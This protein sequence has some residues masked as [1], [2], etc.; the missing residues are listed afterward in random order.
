MQKLLS[1]LAGP[2]WGATAQQIYDILKPQLQ[3]SR[4]VVRQ[5]RLL[6]EEIRK[7]K[8]AAEKGKFLSVPDLTG[9]DEN[10]NLF[11]NEV[12]KANFQCQ[13]G[14]YYDF[15]P[16]VTGLRN[17][18]SIPHEFGVALDFLA[19]P[20]NK[21]TIQAFRLNMIIGRILNESAG[22]SNKSNAGVAGEDMVGALLNAAGLVENIDYRR[23]FKSL[24][25][26][27]TDFVI[28]NVKDHEDHNVE[29]FIAT[30][31]S[32]ND[33]ARLAASELK[34]G[35]QQYLVTGNGTKA[36]TKGLYSIGTQILQG[37]KQDNVRLVCY[38]PEIAR[39]KAR[40]ADIISQKGASDECEKR[41]DYLDT[42]ALSF[43]EFARKL[44][45]RFANRGTSSP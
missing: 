12:Y 31:L 29:V 40:L 11:L 35:G 13:Q 3:G 10:I 21:S 8:I 7:T 41:L 44:R 28:P 38:G 15:V 18:L 6:D 1:D 22:Q 9:L 14:I 39:E 26:S 27:D 30:Q 5:V 43:E 16:H 36:S 17:G 20:A 42:H 45:L 4:G 2:D 37:Y 24:R 23:Q 33:R 34:K 25:G 19:D 32:T